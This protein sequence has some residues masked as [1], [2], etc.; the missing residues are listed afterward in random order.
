V[1]EVTT[2][3]DFERLTVDGKLDTLFSIGGKTDD[4]VVSAG[5]GLRFAVSPVALEKFEVL[6]DRR[7]IHEYGKVTAGFLLVFSWIEDIVHTWSVVVVVSTND[8]MRQ[9]SF[10][11]AYVRKLIARIDLADVTSKWTEIP[12]RVC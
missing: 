11:P 9:R 1:R 10:A 5:L 3:A 8:S 7:W 2:S 4:H 12:V 6:L